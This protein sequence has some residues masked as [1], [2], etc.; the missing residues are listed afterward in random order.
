MAPKPTYEELIHRVRLLETERKRYVKLE[1]DLNRTLQF[2]ASLLNAMPTP[3]FFK[4][5]KG[6]YLGCNPAFTKIMGVTTEK[7]RGKTV[8]EL[9][10]SKHA[11]VYH[12][13]DIELIQNPSHQIYEFEI[14]DKNGIIRPVIFY[15]NV[16]YDD[17]NRVAGL[18][19]GFIDITERKKFEK[20]LQESENRYR[21]VSEL[22]S[23]YSYSFRV[24]KDGTLINEWVT[25]ALSRVTG[26]SKIE[27]E[28][29]G[30]WEYLIHPDD[31]GL[32]QN[33]LRALLSNQEKTVEYRIKNKVGQVRW[34]LDYAR[35]VLDKTEKRVV[36]IEG[37][38]KDITERKQSEE[39][40][41]VSHERFLTVLDSIDATVYVADMETYEV[42]FMNKNMVESFG[43][44]MTGETCWEVFRGESDP[45]QHCS[46]DRLIDKNGKPT[47]L[48]VW[49]G[50]NPI[51]EKWYINYDRAIEWIDGRLVRLQVAT[52]ITEFKQMEKLLRQAHKMEAIGTLAGGIA[53]DFNNLLM[54]IHG[55]AS[56]LSAELG[57][58]HPQIEH[59]KA[60][61]DYVK[62][63]AALTKQ[64]LGFAR[65]GKYNVE[66][67]SINEL[68]LKTAD[69]FGRT[70]KEIRIHKKFHPAS[71][72]I[73]GDKQ[74]I[75][76]LLLNL[77]INA[78]QAMPKGG[79]IYL[80]AALIVLNEIECKSL[81]IEPGRYCKI[82]VTD[83]GIGMDKVTLEKIFDPFFTT[84]EKERGTG[85]G[86][87][88]A[89]G[90][91][92]NHDGMIKVSSEPGHGTKFEIYLPISDRKI[93]RKNRVEQGLAKGAECILLVDDEEMILEVGKAMLENLGY[94]TMTVDSGEQAVDT[95][96]K[97]G[98][99]I[100]LVLLDM[101]MPEMDGG[102]AFDTIRKIKPDIPVILSSGYAINGQAGEIMRRG[103]NGFIQK[104]FN[105][106]EL[107]NI[108]RKILDNTKKVDNNYNQSS[109]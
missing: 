13:K 101:I 90:I 40:L 91:V 30:G 11:K 87:A 52:D 74:Q 102:K 18:V 50:E 4:D 16:F 68:L 81:N 96:Q 103:C 2:T 38:V 67:L 83:T 33:Q 78:W 97:K 34:M 42:L 20:A 49:Q 51:T 23:D 22:T 48:Y 6:R 82:S 46:N 106:S 65:G 84:K 88:S 28:A 9:W 89:Y 94:N 19:G 56:L 70:H 77:Y 80:E 5:L 17:N 41:R 93:R 72:V 66:P 39:D 55:R 60:I 43:K 109:D 15:K 12:Q 7:L 104:P 8:M 27:L 29:L 57:A 59:S 35:P 79:T 53:H 105:L 95:I 98:D 3:I 63:A 107:S 21:S 99:Q 54:G 86:L 24:E 45:C 26:Y 47:G 71:A 108:I 73:E 64:L 69:M 1:A 10:P 100:D 31:L 76:Q 32:A 85:L 25:G 75:E 44:D 14:K 62:S 58:S 36:R 61:E 37:A 92:K